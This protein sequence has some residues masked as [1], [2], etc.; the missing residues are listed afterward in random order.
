MNEFSLCV[1]HKAGL[2]PSSGGINRLMMKHLNKYITPL[3][4]GY[5]KRRLIYYSKKPLKAHRYFTYKDK[6]H[7][8]RPAG[9]VVGDP[10]FETRGLG[11]KSRRLVFVMNTCSQVMAVYIYYYQYNLYMYDLCMF[12]R[13]LA[14]I[15]QVRKDT[16]FGLDNW[17]ECGNLF[18]IK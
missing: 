3:L 17:C 16:L 13:Y 11:F 6:A 18:K 5:R 14:S 12:I 15:T 1:I 10:D 7:V 8:W 4:G 9:L 2:C